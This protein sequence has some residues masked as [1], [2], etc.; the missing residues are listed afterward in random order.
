M[1]QTS[2]NHLAQ[3]QFGYLWVATSGGLSRFDGRNFQNFGMQDGLSS[4]YITYLLETSDH[5]LAIGTYNGLT[6]YNGHSFTQHKITS[7]KGKSLEVRKIFEHPDGRLLLLLPHSQ[8]AFWDGDTTR[9]L[10]VPDTLQEKYLS[11][12]VQNQDGTYWATTYDGDLLRFDGSQWEFVP[13]THPDHPNFNGLYQDNGGKLWLMGEQGIFTYQPGDSQFHK[14][15]FTRP[16]EGMVF[17]LEQDRTGRMWAATSN[18]I[19]YFMPD[20]GI[21]EHNSYGLDG[22][23]VR[24]IFEDREGNLWFG[25]YDDGM[26]K[27]RGETFTYLRTEHGMYEKS[28]FSIIKGQRGDYWFS[29]IS[30]G[31]DRYDG[32]RFYHYGQDEGLSNEFIY[33]SVEDSLGNL[34]FGSVYGLIRYDGSAFTNIYPD[35]LPNKKILSAYQDQGGTLWFGTARGPVRYQDGTFVSVPGQDGEPFSQAVSTILQLKDQRMV[36]GTSEGIHVLDQGSVKPLLGSNAAQSE[37]VLTMIEDRAGNLWFATI[38]G[39]LY[40][41]N[42]QTE[43]LIMVHEHSDV[44]PG[45][46]YTM[47]LARDGS[48]VMGTQRGVFQLMLNEQ[49]QVQRML[50][51]GKQDGFLGMEANSNATFVEEDGSIWIG[52]VDGAYKFK[53]NSLTNTV[54]MIPHLSGVQLHYQSVDWNQYVDTV[55][56][57]FQ[58]PV[59][60]QLSHKQNHLIFSYRA[61][62]LQNAD[63]VKYQFKLGNFDEA[64]SPI[65][66]R[67][68]AVYANIPP[69]DYQFQV[70]AQNV[71]GQ[72]SPPLTFP[73][74]V[75]PPFWQTWWFYL[76]LATLIA[77]LVRLYSLWNLR[78]ERS[79]RRELEQEVGKRTQEIQHLNDN[80]EERV[81]QRTYELQAS[82][83]QLEKEVQLRMQHQERVA[84][85]ER[86]YRLLVNNLREMIFKTDLKGHFTFLN[87]QWKEFTGYTV[88]ESLGRHFVEIVH[89]DE[90][91]RQARIQEEIQEGKIPYIEEELRLVKKDGTMVWGKLSAR[92][93]RD[94]EGNVTG[95][96]GSLIDIDQRKRAE[97]ALRGSEEK[98]R[99][100]AENTQDIITLQDLDMRYTYVSPRIREVAG[101]EPEDLLGKASLDFLHPDDL[102]HYKAFC[103]KV[104]GQRS[105]DGTTL[106]FKIKSGKY[107]YYET[108]LKP[109]LDENQQLVHFISSSRDVTDKVKLTQE[110]E[111]VREKVA[112]D[113]HDEMGNNLASISV[114]SQIIQSKLGA[115][116]NGIAS[117]LT[118]IDTASKNLFYGTRDFI[119]AIDPK[120]D[121][122]Q[123]VYFNLKD[124]GDELFE[125][126]GVAFLANF[127]PCE[128]QQSL[129]LPSG[130]SRQIVLIFKEALTNALKYAKAQTVQLEFRVCDDAFEATL[131][132]DG[133]GFDLQASQPAFRG[134]RNMRDRARKINVDLQMASTHQ[135]GTSI[136]LK[137]KITQNGV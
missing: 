50:S 68:E 93:E 91:G 123:E 44:P 42:L 101:H 92:P 46:V 95:F 119:W 7:D 75:A 73:F 112:Q 98:Y 94:E 66:D 4:S 71:Q 11:G 9:L 53:P 23:V 55:K 67:T 3:D 132:D 72:W 48:L 83:C 29:H 22:S 103:Q 114:L 60:P 70:R 133:I 108:F 84:R 6:L 15:Q 80:L 26:F 49:G 38:N 65:T 30:G 78:N 57:W 106:R 17:A 107:H 19:F 100:L 56:S 62:S 64:W 109:I 134:I 31:I 69:G 85:Q 110:I 27:F 74:Q 96:S 1:P 105:L 39:L 13:I 8:L 21:V 111:K 86:E 121:N 33:C 113:F 2:V 59:S 40:R 116:T 34:W 104:T 77:V 41:F 14:Y 131:Q 122:V 20:Q 24:D 35:A 120:N 51:Y 82:T 87:P 32:E 117:L 135:C 126:T 118:K 79:R 37:Y 81:L 18:G 97:F 115:Q 10:T 99:F 52:T 47:A 102:D 61:V 25:A 16:V 88:A 28:I 136:H 90:R 127:E 89:A 45:M 36:F 12:M 54:P 43:E 63:K 5:R 124:F 125:N 137:G 129:K 128:G 76:V 58:I 130:W